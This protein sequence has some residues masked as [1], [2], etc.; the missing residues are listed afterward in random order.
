MKKIICLTAV[1][2]MV[3]S[4]AFAAGKM[5][6]AAKDLP[7]LKGTWVGM[8]DFGDVGGRAA[9]SNCTLEILNDKVPVQAKLTVLNVPDFVAPHLGTMS[10]KNEF[11]LNDGMIT[12]QGSILWISPEKN[13]FELSMG[14]EKYL[15]ATY[16]Y[17]TIKGTALLEKK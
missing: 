16:W 1:V 4:V 5:Q 3:V 12:S 10:G 14:R 9:S 15:D 8:L 6:I 17:R 13:V 7:G 11:N 2:L